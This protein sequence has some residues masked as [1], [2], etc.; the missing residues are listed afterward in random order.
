MLA[1]HISLT[2]LLFLVFNHD[3]IIYIAASITAI[4]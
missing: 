2:F 1:V 3:F 4:D